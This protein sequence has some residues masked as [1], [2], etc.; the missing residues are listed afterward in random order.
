MRTSKRSRR[1][2]ALTASGSLVAALAWLPGV[3][4][5]ALVHN[6]FGVGGSSSSDY[7]GT[8]G[9]NACL[10]TSG[11][12]TDS[13]STTPIDF[14]AGTRTQSADLN[15]TFTSTAN[16]ADITAVN[17][18][19]KGS[20]TVS[21]S[22]G[23]LRTFRMGGSG[24]ISIIR[25]LGN[26]TQCATSA[27]MGVTSTTD[28]T[29]SKPGW[30]YVTRDTKKPAESIFIAVDNTHN[31]ALL[32]EEYFGGASHATERAFLTPGSFSIPEWILA[33]VAGG[34]GI[35]LKNGV[36]TLQRSSLDTQMTGTF[37]AAG[38]A[39]GGTKGAAGRFV[40]FPG[41]ISCSHHKATL[42]WK[43][44]AAKV[45]GGS[46]YVNGKKKASVSNP[47]AG[48]H[49]VLRHLSKTAD[50]TITAKLSLKSG[51]KAAAARAYVPCQG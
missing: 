5:S 29:E 48:H 43:S 18:H 38:S 11:A 35:F 49:V 17:G 16:S 15:T 51:G 37:Y 12:G 7:T 34:S 26:A 33:V 8:V 44:G 27:I 31:R 4:A 1:T 39:Y 32:F 2:L 42:T 9:P 45:A 25:A 22:H 3:P 41:S 19:Y 36:G 13:V 23:D 50:D 6:Q 24:Q 10:V 28:F 46:F 47:Q 30:L 14:S 21:K 40:R 20:L